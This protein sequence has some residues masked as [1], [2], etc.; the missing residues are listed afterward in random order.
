M[1]VVQ[2]EK[3]VLDMMFDV[4]DYQTQLIAMMY[5]KIKHIS[6]DKWLTTEEVASILSI[7][8]RKVRSMKS[9]GQLGFIKKGKTC[10]YKP[11]DVYNR[12]KKN[13]DG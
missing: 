10:L 6:P 8:V 11:E 2:I 9:L 4:M 12:I 5:N 13:T 3:E 7:S 1:E